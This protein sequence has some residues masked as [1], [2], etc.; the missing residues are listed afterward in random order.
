MLPLNLKKLKTF[1]KHEGNIMRLPD[2]CND[3]PHEDI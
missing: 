2:P 3:W 1:F